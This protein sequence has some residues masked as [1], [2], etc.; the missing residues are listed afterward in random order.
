[1]L[2]YNHS[3]PID[4]ADIISVDQ[5]PLNAAEAFYL[6]EVFKGLAEAY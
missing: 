3:M 6:P 2:G 4:E 5:A 1:M